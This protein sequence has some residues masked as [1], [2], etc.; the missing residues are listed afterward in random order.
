MIDRFDRAPV[1]LVS[2]ADFQQCSKSSC[3]NEPTKGRRRSRTPPIEWSV[4]KT[5]SHASTGERSGAE[6]GSVVRIALPR[7]ACA[8]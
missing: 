2:S 7:A 6:L 3:L 4:V 1:L 8:L 5:L